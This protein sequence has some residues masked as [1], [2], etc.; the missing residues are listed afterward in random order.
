MCLIVWHARSPHIGDKTLLVHGN[1]NWSRKNR[2]SF[3][4]SSLVTKS[5]SGTFDHIRSRFSS[6]L[7]NRSISYI[8]Q[9]QRIWFLP[10]LYFQ[11]T[12]SFCTLIN[13]TLQK[14]ESVELVRR[15]IVINNCIHILLG[16]LEWTRY[17]LEWKERIIRPG[18]H[19]GV[20]RFYTHFSGFTRKQKY[21]CSRKH[22]E[23]WLRKKVLPSI[24]LV[25]QKHYFVGFQILVY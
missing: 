17:P 13:D 6:S 1:I 5:L 19:G 2:R 12:C 10:N 4:E 25:K 21:S 3:V 11:L 15:E 9:F 24:Y 16:S 20:Y 8:S 22:R 7:Q 23:T 14:N 18:L